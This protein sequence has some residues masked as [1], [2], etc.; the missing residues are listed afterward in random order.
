VI[1]FRPFRNTD[2]PRLQT[3]TAADVQR[4]AKKY[5]KTENRNVLLLY[6][7]GAN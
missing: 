6:R 5:L 7:K 1:R 3:V 4:V 2:P